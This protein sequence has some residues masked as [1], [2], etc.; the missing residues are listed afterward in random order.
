ME[1]AR[2]VMLTT[3]VTRKYAMTSHIFHL[4]AFS[5]SPHSACQAAAA[6]G[7][8]GESGSRD[9]ER[10]RE[11]LEREDSHLGGLLIPRDRW[12]RAAASTEIQTPSHAAY[13]LPSSLTTRRRSRF[14]FRP[15]RVSFASSAANIPAR[16]LN[17]TPHED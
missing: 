12:A 13:F 7:R 11:S 9:R 15:P 14:H 4:I 1:F 10:E 3:G 5:Y 6:A 17:N 8:A 2:F 16:S